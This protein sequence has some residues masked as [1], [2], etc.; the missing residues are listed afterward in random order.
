MLDK[1]LKFS[2]GGWVS[3]F[4]SFISTP[5]ISNLILPEEYG[6][7]AFILLAFNFGLQIILLGIDQSYVRE[8]YL[9]KA[10]DR[11]TLFKKSLIV[12]LIFSI[13]FFITLIVFHK[14]LSNYLIGRI[15][16]NVIL[17]LG[18]ITIVA[19]IERFASLS[20]RMAQKAFEFS[21]LKIA[22]T[23]VTFIVAV[24]YA[25]FISPDLLAII[26]GNLAGLL[27]SVL[28]TVIISK[29]KLKLNRFSSDISLK[30]L[31]K[32]GIPF[33]PTFLIGWG[34]EAIDRI[35]LKEFSTYNEIGL[36][37][38]ALRIVAI[39]TI[40]QSTFSTFWT[41]IAFAAFE[42]NNDNSKA[43]F[44]RAFQSLSAV[45]FISALMI[46]I[47]KEVII[48]MF[49]AQYRDASLIVPFLV[50]IPLMYTLS[51]V[52][53]GGINFKKK[54][55]F[56]IFISIISALV[57]VSLVYFLVPLYGA[58]GA[59]ISAACAYTVFF[60]SRTFFS[61][62]F[63]PINFRLG[64]FSV[65]V[66][67]LFVSAALNTFSNSGYFLSVLN[68]ISITFLFVIYSGDLLFLKQYIFNFI[69]NR[70]TGI[71]G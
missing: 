17:V 24:V 21:I 33:I 65:A 22:N 3:A 63:F 50:F 37:T 55:H 56:H 25:K 27:V 61:N 12:P 59:A 10:E 57:S 38:V 68:F 34:F 31:I 41:P 54:T 44:N 66:L 71:T 2:I 7:S 43:M 26:F 69:K 53:V 32:Y 51:E 4:I 52:T 30:E 11:A 6:K 23:L 13:F 29:P 28:I 14:P 70:S 35:A 19:T 46:M 45:F 47:F 62:R 20:I 67:I 48:L 15:D 40:L 36:Y 9:I 49:S 18:V 60:Y 5:I 8:Y 64:K 1:F 39:L 58:R 42:E 16:L